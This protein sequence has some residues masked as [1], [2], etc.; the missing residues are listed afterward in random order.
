[1]RL[2]KSLELGK[3]LSK[4]VF[5]AK[6][7][8]QEVIV[9]LFTSDDLDGCAAQIKHVF[10]ECEV[11]D[12][13]YQETSLC[14]RVLYNIK[15]HY[16]IQKKL[17][18]ALTSEYY[19]MERQDWVFDTILERCGD[20][21]DCAQSGERES[22][23][24]E[25]ARASFVQLIH[26]FGVKYDGG[27]Q[28]FVSTGQPIGL[29]FPRLGDPL[30]NFTQ[31]NKWVPNPMYL[32]SVFG[33]ERTVAGVFRAIVSSVSFLLKEL[34][35]VHKDI[36]IENI[37]TEWSGLKSG[38]VNPVLIDFGESQVLGNNKRLRDAYGTHAMLPPEAFACSLSFH[39]NEQYS[40]YSAEKREIW[41]LGCLLH[42][43]IFGYPPY[44]DIFSSKSPIEF[45]L[46]LCD[47]KSEVE[48]P[49]YSSV[50]NI[51]ISHDLKDLLSSM[52]TKAPDRR[53][54]LENVLLHPWVVAEPST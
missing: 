5:S 41:S 52:L 39:S 29:I 34:N 54:N 24:Y 43:L 47:D 42:T 48:I 8:N 37:C 53:P 30:M 46:K 6:Y 26:V 22:Q 40:G 28:A 12:C 21:L 38:K 4:R 44:F 51:D 33:G 32:T 23:V 16:L 27:S 9:K 35:I 17:G 31:N 15:I 2:P 50:M 19:C 11:V 3:R 45:Q 18:M 25:D 10:D 36:K 14:D 13:E 1:M 20:G 7:E 49:N